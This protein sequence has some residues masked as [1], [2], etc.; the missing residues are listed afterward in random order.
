[1]NNQKKVLITGIGTV[2][3]LGINVDEFWSNCIR[4]TSG[5]KKINQ[6]SI[7]E[8]MS[9]IAGIVDHPLFS[10]DEENSLDRVVDFALHATNEAIKD[11]E[12]EANMFPN[13]DRTYCTVATAISQIKSMETQFYKNTNRGKHPLKIS[14][15][16][17]RRQNHFLFNNLNALISQQFGC[18]GGHVTVTTG[19][20]G[21]VDSIIFG[22]NLIRNGHADLV[23]CGA[24]EA[25]ITPLV[26]SAFSQIS[27]TSRRNNDPQ[28]ASRPFDKDRDG[29][30]LAEGAG[31]IILESE[32]SALL[33]NAKIY[34]EVAGVSSNNNCFHMTDI[35][36]DGHSIEQSCHLAIEDADIKPNTISYINTH[37]SSTPQND[38]AE[39]IA[40]KKIFKHHLKNTPVTSIKSQTGHALSAA[41]AIEI[42]SSVLSIRDNVIPPTIN[43][44]EKDS[45][46]EVEVVGNNSLYT[47]VKA[48]LK[49]S[50]GFSGIHSSLIVRE[51]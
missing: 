27:A 17:N 1:M 4:G 49:T 3:P 42:I 14:Q 16:R 41:N 40:F 20:T 30:V 37:G 13:P 18:K 24:S 38:V 43:L 26:V 35:P 10:S 9:Q 34:A 19:C 23:I 36:D 48:V 50:S 7:P 28:G 2:N 45:R 44:C 6:F 47:Q 51:Y 21:G 15:S 32:Q 29:F 25:P 33:R 22:T 11:A 8:H 46:C 31:I 12:L 5:V 39:S